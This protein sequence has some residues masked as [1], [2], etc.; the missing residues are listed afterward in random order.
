MLLF[1][2]QRQANIQLNSICP[3]QLHLT[4]G[5]SGG[6]RLVHREIFQRSKDMIL[7]GKILGF[8][9]ISSS[10]WEIRGTS[11]WRGGDLATRSRGFVLKI[12]NE[13]NKAS[14]VISE[15]QGGPREYAEF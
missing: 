3:R 13:A 6:E 12:A 1:S 4:D 10:D 11:S 5:P 15:N 7:Q 2:S 9:S 14:A 8:Q